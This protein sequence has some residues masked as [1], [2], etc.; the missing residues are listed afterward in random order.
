MHRSQ[1]VLRSAVGPITNRI[2][3]ALTSPSPYTTTSNHVENLFI[4]QPEEQFG[5]EYDYTIAQESPT[6]DGP[7]NPLQ[8]T[9]FLTEP[10]QLRDIRAI[11]S[12]VVDVFDALQTSDH[13]SPAQLS[14]IK[15]V[16]ETASDPDIMSKIVNNGSFQEFMM[17]V[18]ALLSEQRPQLAESSSSSSSRAEGSRPRHS[19]RVDYDSEQEYTSPHRSSASSSSASSVTSEQQLYESDSDEET[20]FLRG[21]ARRMYTGEVDDNSNTVQQ[22]ALNRLNEICHQISPDFSS[23]PTGRR[24]Q[25]PV[26]CEPE[27]VASKP[28]MEGPGMPGVPLQ[29]PEQPPPPP[30]PQWANPLYLFVITACVI[31]IT[32]LAVTAVV[33]PSPKTWSLLKSGFRAVCNRILA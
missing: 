11:Q 25:S 22:R 6:F 26:N 21:R 13:M 7:T 2:N 10:V 14:L 8:P 15:T 20:S 1:Q 4:G 23:S 28:T 9:S 30:T 17:F 32:I 18:P 5:T 19:L 29:A 24:S 27:P 31:P 3:N 16:R 33:Y 12:R